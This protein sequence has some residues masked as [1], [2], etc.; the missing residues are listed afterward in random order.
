M[1]F[2]VD[3]TLY[4]QKKLRLF[5]L[6]ELLIYYLIRPHKVFQLNAIRHFRNE[7]EKRAL[8]FDRNINIGHNQYLWC[9]EK[10]KQW[11]KGML[12]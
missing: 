8:M 2:D 6:L 7:R 9:R 4:N 12:I 10:V 3:G 11:V 1:I 5:M